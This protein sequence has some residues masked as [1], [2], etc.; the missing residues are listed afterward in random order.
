VI[1]RFLGHIGNTLADFEVSFT[2]DDAQT[3]EVTFPYYID[4]D[5]R[6]GGGS[7][8]EPEEHYLK[9]KVDADL[10]IEEANENNNFK[11]QILPVVV[12][13]PVV[14]SSFAPG[15]VFVALSAVLVILAVVVKKRRE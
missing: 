10:D 5:E 7:F 6:I 13:K 12:Y 9:V 3:Q 4:E 1:V 11:E 8:T 14:V 2:K 15:A